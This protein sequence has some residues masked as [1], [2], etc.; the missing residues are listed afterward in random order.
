[1]KW[2]SAVAAAMAMAA[3]A[4]LAAGAAAAQEVNEGG[5]AVLRGLDKINASVGTLDLPSGGT[6][7]FGGLTIRLNECRYPVD[8]PAGDAFAFVTISDR[9]SDETLF[10]G[11]MI[12]SSPALN[13]LEHPRYDIWVLR[14]KTE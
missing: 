8:D 7:E 12:A 14:C 13:A 5:G 6:T 3:L 10:S 11:W 4:P 1:M 9:D 2:R